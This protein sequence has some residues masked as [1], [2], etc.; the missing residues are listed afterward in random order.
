[1]SEWVDTTGWPVMNIS[2]NSVYKITDYG[3]GCSEGCTKEVNLGKT[4][5]TVA[6]KDGNKQALFTL[7][8]GCQMVSELTNKVFE[9]NK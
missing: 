3:K 8:C 4:T 6:E 7:E 9:A 2:E 1:M 5:R